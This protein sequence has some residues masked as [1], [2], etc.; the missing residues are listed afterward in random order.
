MRSVKENLQFKPTKATVTIPFDIG[1]AVP[2][3]DAHDRQDIKK[4][5]QAPRIDTFFVSKSTFF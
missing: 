4:Y 1:P 5:L 2:A 3:T